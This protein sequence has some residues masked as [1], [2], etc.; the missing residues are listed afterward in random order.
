MQMRRYDDEE[1]EEEEQEEQEAEEESESG[2]TSSRVSKLVFFSVRV[3]TIKLRLLFGLF[4]ARVN[5]ENFDL[6]L[7]NL[8]MYTLS[9]CFRSV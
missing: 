8:F 1:G 9:L 4:T 6:L 3:P 7:F 5:M 2:D